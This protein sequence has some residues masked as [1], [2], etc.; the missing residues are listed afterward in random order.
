MHTYTCIYIF[1][2]SIVAI[3]IDRYECYEN[4]RR[5]HPM[6]YLLFNCYFLVVPDKQMKSCCVQYIYILNVSG[7]DEYEWDLS[8]DKRRKKYIVLKTN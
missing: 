7:T 3:E 5:L 6:F 8:D 4:P 2:F 1:L